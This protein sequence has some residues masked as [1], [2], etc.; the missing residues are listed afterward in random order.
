M[1]VKIINL[2]RRLDRWK[3]ILP[4]LAAFG[5]TEF[6]RFNAIE[7]GF[8]GFNHSVSQALHGEREILI[9][10]DDCIF[11]GNIDDL[12]R[13]KEYL[14]N[15]W[16]CLYLGANVRSQRRHHKANIWHCSD[17]WTSHA[18]LYSDKGAAYVAANFKPETDPIYDEWLRLQSQQNMKCF[19][20]KP[21]LAI[22]APGQSDIWGTH[23]DY[24]IKATE[25]M[26][27]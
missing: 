11:H 19:I 26:L 13:A 22:Q 12:I 4:Q 16:D 18:I 17:A 2:E 1:K 14:P 15:D 3:S 25:G 20:I 8:R 7:G 10:E 24:G 23:A 5:I 27:I 21:Y 6:E 9:L